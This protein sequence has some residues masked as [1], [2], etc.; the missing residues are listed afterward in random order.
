MTTVLDVAV[1]HVDDF[2]NE[3]TPVEEN[4]L[5]SLVFDFDKA[6]IRKKFVRQGMNR[7]QD[8]AT[9]KTRYWEKDNVDDWKINSAKRRDFRAAGRQITG[10]F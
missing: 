3:L 10:T 8:H 7:R 1:E 4:V 6:S 9:R 5:F 2:A